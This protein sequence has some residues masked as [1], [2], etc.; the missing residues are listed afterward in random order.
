MHTHGSK[1]ATRKQIGSTISSASRLVSTKAWATL[2]L[3][4]AHET[5]HNKKTRGLIRMKMVGL[6]QRASNECG[7]ALR[8]TPHLVEPAKTSY[9]TAE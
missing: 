2:A 1:L 9:G 4:A 5:A 3:N 7:R 6:Q 8:G